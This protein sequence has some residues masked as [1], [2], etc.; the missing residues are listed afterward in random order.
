[1][2]CI[3]LYVLLEKHWHKWQAMWS[4][5]IPRESY[6]LLSTS[7]IAHFNSK[8]RWSQWATGVSWEVLL[9]VSSS[10]RK[11]E[12]GKLFS[13]PRNSH[14]LSMSF[15]KTEAKE[16]QDWIYGSL[17]SWHFK[18][19]RFLNKTDKQIWSCILF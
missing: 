9:L 7:R 10:L 8:Q 5:Y 13:G 16:V 17:F 11:A 4:Y 12:F 6:S 14:R 19:A 18:T 1:M 2:S 15:F 3:L